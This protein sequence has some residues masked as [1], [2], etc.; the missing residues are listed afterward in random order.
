MSIDWPIILNLSIK[1]NSKNKRLVL[2]F[3]QILPLQFG[4]EPI[5]CVSFDLF[6]RL[7]GK[8]WSCRRVIWW[9]Q[10]LQ[11]LQASFCS[12]SWVRDAENCKHFSA[13]AP[14]QIVSHFGKT[15]YCQL[16]ANH[17]PKWFHS[18]QGHDFPAVACC[19][20]PLSLIWLW[21][22]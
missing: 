19:T 1:E 8:E 12:V 6:T 21:F 5:E 9:A 3:F 18:M 14:N 10:Q 17:H 16:I 11:Q 20:T 22:D 13:R 4:R 15:R 7:K 2:P